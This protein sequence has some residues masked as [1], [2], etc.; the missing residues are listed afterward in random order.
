MKNKILILFVVMLM[1]GFATVG[2]RTQEAPPAP[3][4]TPEET[5]DETPEMTDETPE[6]EMN[7]ED[8]SYRG[9]L[10]PNEKGWTSVVDIVVE[11][12]RITEVDYDELDEEGNRKSENEE[13]NELWESAAGISAK[14]AYPALEQQLIEVQDVQAVEVITGATLTT[15]DFKEVVEKAVEEGPQ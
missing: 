1:V 7:Y 6:G 3:T 13:Y 4:E 12:G 8:G 9:E 11:N 5:P 15:K 10:E 2:C 14:E